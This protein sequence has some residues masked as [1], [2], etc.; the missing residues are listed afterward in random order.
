HFH[1]L[2][3]P[4]EYGMVIQSRLPAATCCIHNIICIHDP[5]NVDIPDPDGFDEDDRLYLTEEEGNFGS[6]Q[7]TPLNTDSHRQMNAL[8]D[9]IVVENWDGYCAEHAR[10]GMPPIIEQLD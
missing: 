5:D 6:L 10:W 2:V 9:T 3:L 8:C 4:P 1:A 7:G